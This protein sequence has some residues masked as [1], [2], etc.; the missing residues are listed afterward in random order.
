MVKGKPQQ[1]F[2]A[3]F[4]LNA[5]LESYATGNISE[6]AARHG[7]H[8]TQLTNWRKQ[9]LT[10]GAGIFKRGASGKTEEQRKIEAMEK[11]IGRLAFQN[12]I[13]KKTAELL[14]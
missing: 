12:D 9:L 3:E 10:D 13:L 11:T 6:T 14:G 1:K 2:S 8:I 7:V 4:K 5:V